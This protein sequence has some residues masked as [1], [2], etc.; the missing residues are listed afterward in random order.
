MTDTPLNLPKITKV[1]KAFELKSKFTPKGDQPTAIEFLIKGLNENKR[2][3]TLLG[4]T[5]TGKT[6]TMA[7]IIQDQQKPTLILAHNKTLAAQLCTEFQEFFPNNAVSYFVSY[8]DYYQPEAYMPAS[9]TYI[10]KEATINDEINRHRHAATYNLLTRD[11]VIIISSVSCIYGLGSVKDYEAL[12]IELK[13]GEEIVRNDLLKQFSEIQYTRVASDF[14]PGMFHVMGDSVE[15]YPPAE[16]HA[17]RIEFFGDEIEGITAID[18][19]TGEILGSHEKVVIFPAKHAVTQKEKIKKCVED[20]KVDVKA[21]V[22]WYQEEGRMVEAERIQ[23]RSE[24]DIEM[25][26]ETGYCNGIENYTQYLSGEKPGMPPSTLLDFFPDDF[27]LF[28]DESH[29]TI[30]QIGAMHNGNLSRKNT[31]IDHGFRLPSAHDNRP[32]KFEEFE[33]K[34]NK[35]IYVSATPGKYEYLNCD[36]KK[37]FAQQVIRPT[38]LLDPIISIRPSES[39]KWDSTLHT[40]S[41]SEA[42]NQIDDLNIEIS[43]RIKLNEK[44]LVTTATKKMAEKLS[45]YFDEIGIRSK[46]LHSEIENIERIETIQ[47][48]RLGEL[49]V[50]VGVNLL[51]E[52]LDIPEVSMIA[53]LDADKRGFLR[54]RDA[55]LQNI[56]RAARNSK[57]LV[58][59]YADVMTPAME[60]AIEETDRRRDI[61]RAYNVKHGIIPTTIIKHVK[62]LNIEKKE[63]KTKISKSKKDNLKEWIKE[64]EDKLDIAVQNLEFEKAA[65]LKD[66][67][68]ML[69]SELR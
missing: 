6:F 64:L 62:A 67:I 16:E 34:I 12:A 11:D 29:I 1:H 21:R 54:S 22:K 20:I 60:E 31:L 25:L 36:R 5:G 37:D 49:D 55:L 50:I 24:Y 61:Q 7:N 41:E 57:G 13:V 2:H 45:A 33:G 27:L 44:V 14:K 69:K 48:L 19:F 32:L 23:T 63:R 58:I 53:I 56:G 38:G 66:E 47:A 18:P 17:Y 28:V 4:A 46:Y 65:D 52:G 8:Y 9:D 42:N 10:E 39:E 26:L 59:M 43:N 30:P 15:V 68:E 35:A 3:Q 51:R 40:V